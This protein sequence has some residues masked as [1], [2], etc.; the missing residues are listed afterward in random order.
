MRKI[1]T[2]AAFALALATSARAAPVD[3]QITKI[4]TAQNKVTLKH[5]PITNLEMDAMTMVFVV[6]D[7]AALKAVKVGDKVKFEADRVNGRLTVT[8]IEK[9]K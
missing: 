6:A 5:G 9:A 2:A 4:D 3:G 1:V 8:K 7:P